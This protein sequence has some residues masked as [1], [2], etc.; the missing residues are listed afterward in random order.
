MIDME[1]ES[2]GPG[3]GCMRG[4]RRSSRGQLLR[5]IVW[6]K[7]VAGWMFSWGW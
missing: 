6:R 5:G 1:S 3:S 7:E 4:M 2:T